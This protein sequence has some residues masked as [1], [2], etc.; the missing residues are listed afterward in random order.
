M[1]QMVVSGISHLK[2]SNIR[3]MLCASNRNLSTEL[4][5]HSSLKYSIVAIELIK[6]KQMNI[7]I[8]NV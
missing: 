5:G 7:G 6:P 2:C 1:E 3:Q 4:S 8:Y